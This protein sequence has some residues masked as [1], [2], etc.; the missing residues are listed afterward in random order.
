MIEIG[1]KGCRKGKIE[2]SSKEDCI[3]KLNLFFKSDINVQNIVNL[4]L[5]L[6][7]CCDPIYS[8]KVLNFPF[9]SI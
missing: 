9:F 6:E 7:I 3:M 8:I 5:L 4:G 2:F 1:G